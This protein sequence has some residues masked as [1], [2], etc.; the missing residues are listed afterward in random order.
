MVIGRLDVA[1]QIGKY[2]FSSSVRGSLELSNDRHPVPGDHERTACGSSGFVGRN[3][4]WMSMPNV[5]GRPVF[6]SGSARPAAPRT[7]LHA[8]AAVD[9]SWRGVTSTATGARHYAISRD[10]EGLPEAGQ[11]FPVAWCNMLTGQDSVQ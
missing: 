2:R 4:E 1:E 7:M 11:S 9:P 8:V 10:C 3:S 5:S 6:C